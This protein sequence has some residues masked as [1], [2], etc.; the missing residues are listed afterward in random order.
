MARAEA[1]VAERRVDEALAQ[2]REAAQAPE[3]TAEELEKIANACWHLGVPAAA[4]SVHQRL[5]TLRPRD[6]RPWRAMAACLRRLG[7]DA[8]QVFTL[9]VAA[10]N[11]DAT[12]RAFVE[13]GM[14]CWREDDL[15]RARR[16][17]DQALTV[18]RDYLPA[19][20]ARMQL[21]REV[22]YADEAEGERFVAEWRAGLAAFE[23]RDFIGAPRDQLLSCVGM[24]TNF[25][26]HY[27][28]QDFLDEQRR[29]ARVVA[30]MLEAALPPERAP[31]APRA[32]RASGRLRVGFC[33]A[34][35]RHHTVL[36]LFGRLITNLPRDRFEVLA[37]HTATLR[38]A[39]TE[40]LSRAVD[41]FDT[42]DRD[43]EGWLT[44]LRAAELDVLVYPDIGMQPITQALSA[45]R[46]APVQ[47]ALWGH[48][49]TTGAP[50]ID[51][52]ISSAAMEPDDGTRHY[53]ESLIALPGLG[54]DFAT[55]ARPFDTLREPP[56]VAEDGVR[57]FV[58]QQAYKL[59]P[60]FDRVLARLA[61][62]LPASRLH[63]TPHPA[64]NV[65]AALRARLEASF[66]RE[67]VDAARH[68]AHFEHV[69][70]AGFMSLAA[71]MDVNLDSLGW[72]GGNTTLEILWHD[73]PTVTCPGPLMRQRHTAAILR[74]LDLTELIAS[75]VE[76]YLRIAVELGRSRDWRE[77]LRG[78][79]RERKH[80]L[81]DDATA[82]AAFADA[83]TTLVEKKRRE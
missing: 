70:E 37:F 49:V 50:T 15:P 21:P 8:E 39:D 18:D 60:A 46:L 59:M 73:V 34:H 3:A 6:P 35:L 38:D 68:I 79:I 7:A 78:R 22:I 66:H 54:I 12:A 32:P 63:F 33:S 81:Y 62:A 74:L 61:A 75:D 23:A 13:L 58:A 65:R 20:W 45:R 26:L 83:I 80:R 82:V 31:R 72:S 40:A 17:F 4:L 11:L 30:R 48:P 41:R 53:S 42:G 9:R 77:D 1:L 55:P 2:L 71:R 25:F 51:A 64:A 24:A 69:N 43:I 29:H 19:H 36:K 47:V 56:R 44:T 28:G 52:F 76:D 67:G 27:H 57:Y 5:S 16:A 10:A 14:T